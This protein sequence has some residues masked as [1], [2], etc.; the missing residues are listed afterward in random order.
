[1][2][3]TQLHLFM[4]IPIKRF[5]KEH[6]G[7]SSF[8]IVLAKVAILNKFKIGMLTYELRET[9]VDTVKLALHINKMFCG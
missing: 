1:M 5:K 2:S 9:G 4:I 6:I 8:N 3:K 7:Y